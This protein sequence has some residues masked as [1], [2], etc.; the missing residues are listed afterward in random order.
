[1]LLGRLKTLFIVRIGLGNAL[2]LRINT[3]AKR[4]MKVEHMKV[5]I[6]GSLY[7]TCLS[8]VSTDVR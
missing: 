5:M 1:M 6:G 4:K 7:D 8:F 2:K 3:S